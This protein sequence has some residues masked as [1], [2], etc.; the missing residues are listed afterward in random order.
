MGIYLQN[1]GKIVKTSKVF[2]LESF[3][4]YGTS[5][6]AWWLLIAEVK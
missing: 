5:L 2:P 3:A 1:E 4:V 6:D